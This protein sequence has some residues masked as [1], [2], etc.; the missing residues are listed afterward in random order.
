MPNIH[1]INKNKNKKPIDQLY[2]FNNMEYS[3]L[4]YSYF[5]KG[6]FSAYPLGSYSLTSCAEPI[7]PKTNRMDIPVPNLEQAQLWLKFQVEILSLSR[8]YLPPMTG[9]TLSNPMAIILSI[10]YCTI[11]C[12]RMCMKYEHMG[13]KLY[14]ILQDYSNIKTNIL[15]HLNQNFLTCYNN[16][17]VGASCQ[18]TTSTVVITLRRFKLS[19]TS[20]NFKL[21]L[22]T[23]HMGNK[24]HK[25]SP[26]SKDIPR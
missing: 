25:S 26:R 10:H 5:C 17:I 24:H 18:C 14:Y 16:I 22:F 11:L 13:I 15:N 21:R 3:F 2:N 4:G 7:N 23:V 1:W 9:H 12:N 8:L 19:P 6:R 20:K